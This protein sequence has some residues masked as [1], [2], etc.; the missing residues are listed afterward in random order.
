MAAYETAM[1][2]AD[3]I[4]F[5]FREGRYGDKFSIFQSWIAEENTGNELFL[6]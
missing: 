3:E 6:F 5:A 2:S 1:I 4:F